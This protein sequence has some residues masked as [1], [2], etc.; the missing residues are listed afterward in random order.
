MR[1]LLILVFL[2]HSFVTLAAPITG[3]ITDG[4]TKAHIANVAVVNVHTSAGTVSDEQ[5][6]FSI[7]VSK[8][9]LLEFRKIGYKTLRI[10]I[11]HGTIPPYFKVIMQQGPVELPEFDL[12]AQ[13]RDWKKDS[14]R[15]YELYKG[16]IEFEK[17]DGLDVVRHPFSALSKRNRQIWA[18]Q[19]EYNYWEQQKFIDYTFNE[20]LITS[21]TGLT[22]DSLQFYMKRFR[23]GYDFLRSVNEYSY[24]AYIKESAE[25]FRTGRRKYT[26][27]IRRSA[28]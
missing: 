7:E 12:Q 26:P 15:Y 14:A 25:F 13:A 28:N 17:L 6:R 18:F 5:G 4:G 19:K 3:D 9:D 23:P 21:I 20:K 1:R 22:G 11:P 8:G 2:L 10:R 27:S 24:Y 16:A